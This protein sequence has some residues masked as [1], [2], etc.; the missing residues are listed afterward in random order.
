MKQLSKL[1]VILVLT[2]GLSTGL[3]SNGLNLNG[4]GT[5]AISMGGAFIGLADDYSAVF[6][7]PA[8]LTQMKDMSLSV[9]AVDLI[10]DATYKFDLALVNTSNKNE[11]YISGGLG[12]FKPLSEKVVV[13]IYAYTPSGV[14]IEWNGANLATLSGLTPLKWRSF[15]GIVSVSPTVAIKVTDTLSLGA[16]L[17][18]NYGVMELEKPVNLVVKWGQYSEKL[19]GFAVGATFGMMFKPSDKFSIGA[20]FRTPVKATLSGDSD[21]PDAVLFGL[22]ASDKSERKAT[23]PMWLGAGIAFKP[24]DKLTLTADVQYTNWKKMESIPM[25]F[26]NAAWAATF[27]SGAEIHL[28]WKD[29]TQ[30]RFGAE[31]KVSKSFAL[32]AGYYYDPNPGPKSTQL[33]LLPELSYNFFTF[34]I[35]YSTAKINLDFCI[36]YGSGSDVE[37]GLLDGGMP[38]THGMNILVPNL[39]ITFKL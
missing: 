21:I 23:M 1:V 25:T 5:K 2:V 34:G 33:I 27:E 18:I 12:F 29:T 32:R 4:T 13:G 39:A 22:P 6:W 20:T 19:N 9:F 24:T 16:A 8:G 37:V 10:P 17:N 15:F 7:N 31:Y 38:G 3:Y 26:T 28:K 36:E 14:G 11:N 30:V 35:G